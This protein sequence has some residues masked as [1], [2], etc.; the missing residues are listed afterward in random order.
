MAD[1][2]DLVGVMSL[3]AL[4]IFAGPAARERLAERGL[5]PEDIGL[6]PAAAG[7]PKGLALNGL[8]RFLFG[9]WLPQSRQAVHLVGA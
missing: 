9:D 7:G 2:G 3:N 6:I 1:L 4:Q 5:K 8:D